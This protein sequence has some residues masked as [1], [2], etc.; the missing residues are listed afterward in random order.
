MKPRVKI[1]TNTDDPLNPS[2]VIDGHELVGHGLVSAHVNIDG[3][4]F[5]TVTVVI[6]PGELE[7]DGEYFVRG[8]PPVGEPFSFG[9]KRY[10][11]VGDD[12]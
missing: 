6:E 2:V 3:D 4:S 8:L 12:E 5:P 9:G 10:R 11:V 7:L 1:Q